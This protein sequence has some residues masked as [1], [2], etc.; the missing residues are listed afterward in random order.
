MARRREEPGADAGVPSACGGLA[1]T[2]CPEPLFC[3]FPIETR[4]GSGDQ[5]GTCRSRPEAC[6]EEYDPV[7]GCDGQTYGNACTAAAAGVSVSH[8]GECMP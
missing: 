3:D 5:A 1:G 6:T 8:E 7:C 2:Q 4:C